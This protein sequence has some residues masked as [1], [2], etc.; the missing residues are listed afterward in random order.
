MKG[1]D[2]SEELL[3]VATTV[4]KDGVIVHLDKDLL[5]HQ[6]WKVVCQIS[7]SKENLTK[8]QCQYHLLK[9][10]QEMGTILCH[11][12]KDTLTHCRVINVIFHHDFIDGFLSYNNGRSRAVQET[13]N[14]SQ[15]QCF[16]A[17]I[18]N[19]VN[20][21]ESTPQKTPTEKE[22]P[23]EQQEESQDSVEYVVLT[24]DEDSSPQIDSDINPYGELEERLDDNAN[25]TY[26]NH[27]IDAKL[28]GVNP[29]VS[30]TAK[31]TKAK[32][33]NPYLRGSFPSGIYGSCDEDKWVT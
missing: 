4:A 27:L 26:N 15:F 14:G 23:K 30:N 11:D 16:W 10:S 12:G 13:G 25:K 3:A 20:G 22:Q 21:G 29:A 2:G 24:L 9:T 17:H 19:A 33:L 31:V 1:E 32:R 28:N 8:M 18:A 5:V 6:L 7:S